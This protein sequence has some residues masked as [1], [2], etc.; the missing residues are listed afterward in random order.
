MCAAEWGH[1]NVVV[2]LCTAPQHPAHPYAQNGRALLLAASNDHAK[3]VQTL[4]RYA[5]RL[6][7]D[8][9]VLLDDALRICSCNGHTATLGVVLDDLRVVYGDN[10]PLHPTFN[11]WPAVMKGHVEAV[12]MLMAAGAQGSDTRYL[13]IAVDQGWAQMVRVLCEN[14]VF[15]K[16]II[17]KHLVKCCTHPMANNV[18]VAGVLMDFGA[19]AQPCLPEAVRRG[20]LAMVQQLRRGRN[21]A[22]ANAAS[23]DR[24]PRND[25]LLIAARMG[26]TRML[27]CLLEGE[28]GVHSLTRLGV[29][30]NLTVLAASQL[31]RTRLRAARRARR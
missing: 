17:Q 25:P 29:A 14:H 16:H 23:Y 11:L 10:P 6:L 24:S 2:A 9:P 21:A 13:D 4:L 19:R 15:E 1:E 22:R 27:E 5:P 31:L 26:D 8:M 18:D 12:R 20:D 30:L 28:D 7:S 3:V